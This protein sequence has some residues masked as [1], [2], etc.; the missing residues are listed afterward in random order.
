MRAVF[1]I[2]FGDLPQ[3]KLRGWARKRAICIHLMPN[4]GNTCGLTGFLFATHIQFLPLILLK[5]T[6]FFTD[7]RMNVN[8]ENRTV[9]W[10]KISLFMLNS[11]P[12]STS[13]VQY[14]LILFFAPLLILSPHSQ[15]VIC[16][17]QNRAWTSDS[18]EPIYFRRESHGIWRHCGRWVNRLWNFFIKNID[19]LSFCVIIVCHSCLIITRREKNSSSL[20]T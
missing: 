5:M 12:C 19:F 7:R 20:F 13:F 14:F 9:F 10:G 16:N 2:N 6:Y 4:P 15:G 3:A 8:Q 17:G 18:L 1:N 11:H